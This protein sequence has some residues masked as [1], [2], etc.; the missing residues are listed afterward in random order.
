MMGATMAGTAGPASETGPRPEAALGS[1]SEGMYEGD[2]QCF[3]QFQFIG[4]Q[5]LS[6]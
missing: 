1:G 3:T 6:A 4:V 2:V 5:E